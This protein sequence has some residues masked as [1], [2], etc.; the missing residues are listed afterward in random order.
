MDGKLLRRN[1]K[2]GGLMIDSTGS[3][4]KAAQGFGTS[5]AEDGELDR[6]SGVGYSL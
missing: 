4:L 6:I 2:A 1:I 3:L 5:K